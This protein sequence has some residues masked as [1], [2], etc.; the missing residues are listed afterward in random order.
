MTYKKEYH[1]SITVVA[2]QLLRIITLVAIYTQL[3]VTMEMVWPM[4]APD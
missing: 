4:A 2:L 1:Y 3:L